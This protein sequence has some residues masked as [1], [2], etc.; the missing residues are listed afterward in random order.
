MKRKNQTT[1]GE[2]E[3]FLVFYDWKG[4][5]LVGYKK[6]LVIPLFNAQR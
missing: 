4:L 6:I 3:V 5:G 2:G 1:V